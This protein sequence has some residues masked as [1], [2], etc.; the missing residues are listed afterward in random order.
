M[1][2]DT[3]T[4]GA[5]PRAP[6]VGVYVYGIVPADVDVDPDARGVGDEAAPLTVVRHDQ[7][8]ALVSEVHLDRPLGRSQDLL[9]HEQLLDAAA[10]E[11]PVLP[12][13]FGAVLTDQDAVVDELLAPHYDEF[14]TALDDLRGKA[15]YIVKGRYVEAAVL[16]EIVSG[17][18]EIARLRDGIRDRP[19]AATRNARMRLGEL[20]NQA[21]EAR[22]RVDARKA[23]D[24]LSSQG[25]TVIVREATHELDAVNVAMLAETA[26]EPELVSACED[27]AREWQGLVKLRLLG[28]LAPYDFVARP[29][30]DGHT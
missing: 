14:R 3:K 7:I 26:R 11:V 30:P 19:E 20:V 2:A 8:A 13:R 21:I 4:T 16:T 12:A 24:L 1:S 9:A 22:R 15:Q 28:P 5:A 6:T 23:A 29:Q 17:N 25:V 18:P 27:L 10:T